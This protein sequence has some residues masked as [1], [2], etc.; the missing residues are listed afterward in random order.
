MTHRVGELSGQS[1]FSGLKF[2]P[3]PF[4]QCGNWSSTARTEAAGPTVARGCARNPEVLRH[5]G[6]LNGDG[7]LSTL[8]ETIMEVEHRPLEDYFLLQVRPAQLP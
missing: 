8:P 6:T 5:E 2:V 1:F 3:A 7:F 4:L